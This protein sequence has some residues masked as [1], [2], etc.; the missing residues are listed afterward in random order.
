MIFHSNKNYAVNIQQIKV[1]YAHQ[2]IKYNFLHDSKG[3][4]IW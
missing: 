4:G 1:Y 2:A 3:Q